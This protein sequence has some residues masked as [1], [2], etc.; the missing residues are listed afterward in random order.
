MNIKASS[1]RKLRLFGFTVK[2]Y[3][4][5]EAVGAT[6]QPK[7]E[8]QISPRRDAKSTKFIINK[9]RTLRG[10]RDLRSE[11]IFSHRKVCQ[12]IRRIQ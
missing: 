11:D 6:P 7:K 12:T 5:R 10:L 9:I 3:Q 2:Q 4:Q 1:A 8:K